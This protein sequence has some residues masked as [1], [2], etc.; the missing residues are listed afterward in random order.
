LAGFNV[1]AVI[2]WAAGFILP[3]IGRIAEIMEFQNTFLAAS[4]N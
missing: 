4:P 3:T 2:A 1:R